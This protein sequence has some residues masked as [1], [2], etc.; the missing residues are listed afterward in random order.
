MS[1]TNE[2]MSE[3]RQKQIENHPACWDHG[4]HSEVIMELRATQ[5]ELQ[6]AMTILNGAIEIKFSNNAS[7]GRYNIGDRLHWEYGWG[8]E[9]M[10]FDTVIEACE[11]AL[12]VE[13][14]VSD[15]Q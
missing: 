15:E 5:Q 8:E 3:A 10:D 2:R 7:V 6:S 13:E 1:E 4:T 12:A 11:M 14:D 9:A